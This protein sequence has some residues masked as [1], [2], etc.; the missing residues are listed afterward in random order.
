MTDFVTINPAMDPGAITTPTTGGRD[1]D[2]Y[3]FPSPE[4]EPHHIETEEEEEEVPHKSGEHSE[5]SDDEIP[6]EKVG[7][8]GNINCGSVGHMVEY[9][10]GNV[11]PESANAIP[12]PVPQKKE[13]VPRDYYKE[14]QEIGVMARHVVLN[15]P[16][17]IISGIAGIILL[18]A[19]YSWWQRYSTR[20]HINNVLKKYGKNLSTISPI[21]T[22]L[23]L[24]AYNKDLNAVHLYLAQY[25][26]EP[27]QGA[28]NAWVMPALEALFNK[29]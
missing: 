6:G 5:S 2:D 17:Y 15:N 14:A 29:R 11:I 22:V 25:G 9:A 10:D 16:K 13:E 3:T 4:E 20:Y 7:N 21:Q 27:V 12:I 8:T 28:D 24:A 26:I 23:M 18:R 1:E 19:G